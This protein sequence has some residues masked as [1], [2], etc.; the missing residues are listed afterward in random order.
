MEPILIFALCLI[1]LMIMC[2]CICN[3]ENKFYDIYEDS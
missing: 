1:A 3:E 2:I